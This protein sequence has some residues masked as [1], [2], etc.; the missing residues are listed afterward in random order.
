MVT[1]QLITSPTVVA[2]VISMASEEMTDVCQLN[3]SILWKYGDRMRFYWAAHDGW[4]AES[5]ITEIERTLD[6]GAAKRP[7]AASGFRKEKRVRCDDGM[8]HAFCINDRAF[9]L[10]LL[11]C[12]TCF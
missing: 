11:R 3:E 5:S 9:S 6:E 4:V 1:T 2:A 7:E 12:E 10:T 8:L